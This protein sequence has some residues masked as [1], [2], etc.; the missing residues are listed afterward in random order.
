K[1]A[2]TR[3][4]ADSDPTS[5]PDPV[6]M[7]TGMCVSSIDQGR[8]YGLL[9]R[10]HPGEDVTEYRTRLV[11]RP[12][13]GVLEQPPAVGEV[14]RHVAGSRLRLGGFDRNAPP[15]DLSRELGQLDE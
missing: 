5:P 15:R 14:D 12:P 7:A 8:L 1:P 9:V 11:A 3:W 10:L 2:S 6:T 13:R 4:R